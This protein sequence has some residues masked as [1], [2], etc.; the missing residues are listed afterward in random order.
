MK[1][2]LV[3]TLVVAKDEGLTLVKDFGWKLVGPT[4]CRQK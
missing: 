2:A 3:M 1:I 4:L